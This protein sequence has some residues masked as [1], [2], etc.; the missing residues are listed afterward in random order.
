MP[1]APPDRFALNPPREF[2]YKDWV[3]NLPV[4]QFLH[5]DQ[6]ATDQRN[7]ARIQVLIHSVETR[8]GKDR[9]TYRFM[10]ARG[11]PQPDKIEITQLYA[12]HEVKHWPGAF[13][14]LE[15]TSFVMANIEYDDMIK[16]YGPS[17]SLTGISAEFCHPL[18]GSIDN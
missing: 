3:I 13:A 18:D 8:F 5:H 12:F 6:V 14:Q 15:W 1:P 10:P 4:P 9:C 16:T 7:N 17:A 2:G 11:L